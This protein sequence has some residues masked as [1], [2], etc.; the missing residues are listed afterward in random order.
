MEHTVLMTRDID[1]VAVPAEMRDGEAVPV[2]EQAVEDA[3]QPEVGR[4]LVARVV[5]AWSAEQD[6]FDDDHGIGHEDRIARQP[7]AAPQHRSTA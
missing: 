2:H 6:E 5:A 1:A 7:R 4:H 3:G